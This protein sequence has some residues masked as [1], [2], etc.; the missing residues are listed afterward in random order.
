MVA[1]DRIELPTRGFSDPWLL[2]V[3]YIQQLYAHRPRAKLLS[4]VT[5]E[6]MKMTGVGHDMVTYAIKFGVLQ[7]VRLTVL[8]P[9]PT[10]PL[11]LIL[12]A[13]NAFTP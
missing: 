8:T 5:G 11:L 12:F 1:R 7:R 2:W 13:F 3:L 4:K 10:A 6:D 9:A